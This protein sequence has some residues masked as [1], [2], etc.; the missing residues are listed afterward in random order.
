MNQLSNV[1]K[2]LAIVLATVLVALAIGIVVVYVLAFVEKRGRWEQF[3][4]PPGNIVRLVA[5]DIDHVVVETDR[6]ET[7]E[8]QCRTNDEYPC[9]EKVDA[10]EQVHQCTCDREDFPEPE[11]KIM[12]RLCACEGYEYIIRAQYVLRDDGSL[13][14]WKIEIYPYGQVAR[15]IQIMGLSLIVGVVAGIVIVTNWRR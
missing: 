8:V 15:F 9:L 4:T 3:A 6:G 7:Y 2:A 12:D 5:G 11:G 1:F 14:R 13:W 10:P